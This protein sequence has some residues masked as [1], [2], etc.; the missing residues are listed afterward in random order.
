MNRQNK[1]TVATFSAGIGTPT[2]LNITEKKDYG[3]ISWSC[4]CAASKAMEKLA[5]MGK[6]YIS[7][8]DAESAKRIERQIA[9]LGKLSKFH[10]GMSRK[11]NGGK[12]G[13]K[14]KKGKK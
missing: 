9:E 13:V 2:S 3:G 6:M 1:Q 11:G 5:E 14:N 4:Y 12:V 7:K 10:L 8:G